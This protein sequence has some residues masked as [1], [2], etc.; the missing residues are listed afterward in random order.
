VNETPTL[1]VIA[2]HPVAGRV[3][4]RLC[5]PCSP[6]ESAEIAGAALDD[7]LAAIATVRGVRRVLAL[8]GPV[9]A[10]HRRGLDVIEQRGD[11]LADRIAAAFE[12][13]GGPAFLVGMDTPQLRT[14][15]FDGALAALADGNGAVIGRA[16]DGGYWGIG[17]H[18][19]DDRVF[20]EIPMSVSAT[21]A[22]QRTRLEDLGYRIGE[23]P[24]YR[25][26]DTWSDA[27]VVAEIAP[28]TRFARAV[29]RV[30]A[31]EVLAR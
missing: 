28:T 23:L 1:I 3:K 11:G 31:M 8:D 21:Y 24:E 26:V 27:I 30:H 25:D 13:V 6:S 9:E 4:T 18:A 17:L 19:P 2:K 22:E 5:P 29:R 10:W 12:D 15:D 14:A 20:R 7:T 16:S